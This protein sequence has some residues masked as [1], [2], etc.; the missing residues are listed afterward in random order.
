MLFSAAND[1][2]VAIVDGIKNEQIVLFELN[3]LINCAQR[4]AK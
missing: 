1:A 2:A 4:D 3:S